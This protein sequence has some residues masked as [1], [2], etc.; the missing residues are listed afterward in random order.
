MPHPLPPAELHGN[1]YMQAPVPFLN[2]RRSRLRP[3]RARD[4]ILFWLN[5]VLHLNINWDYLA[6]PEVSARPPAHLPVC[7]ASDEVIRGGM[8]P[9]YQTEKQDLVGRRKSNSLKKMNGKRETGYSW[10]RGEVIFDHARVLFT[11][12]E[13]PFFFFKL[14]TPPPPP[15]IGRY[16]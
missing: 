9:L 5:K 15:G 13:V 2:K 14:R 16:F 10:R 12:D 3:P 11:E 6:F 1:K 7:S 8:Q 4:K